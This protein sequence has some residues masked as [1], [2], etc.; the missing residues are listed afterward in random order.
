MAYVPGF[1]NDIFISYSHLDELTPDDGP[2]W[3]SDF[4]RHLLI[5]VEQ[6]LGAN[7]KIWRDPRLTGATDFTKELE[8]QVRGSAMLVAIVSP[9]YVNS[10]WC[11]WEL[12]GFA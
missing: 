11:D 10:K 2:G 9:G 7:I 4:H 5:Q 12:S 8:K 1:S 6:E 3:V